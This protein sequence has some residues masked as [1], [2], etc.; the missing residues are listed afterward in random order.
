M[1]EFVL[2]T[3][4]LMQLQV[5]SGSLRIF[6]GCKVA[7]L[8]LHFQKYKLTRADNGATF[9]PSWP[10]LSGVPMGSRIASRAVQEL[11]RRPPRGR[12]R[13]GGTVPAGCNIRPRVLKSCGS[14][15]M[16]R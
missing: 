12:V 15:P 14:S 7:K 11:N 16:H 13:V 9:F 1:G 5:S 6:H 2:C 3:L 4:T 10:L 8:E